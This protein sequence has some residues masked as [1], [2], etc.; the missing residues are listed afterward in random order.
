MKL[1]TCIALLLIFSATASFSQPRW[2]AKLRAKS[3]IDW[4][5][6][7]LHLSEDQLSKS[8]N[9][10]QVFQQQM[11]KAGETPETRDKAQQRLMRKKDM[12]MKAVLNKTQYQKYYDNQIQVRQRE[13]A[14]YKDG[15]RPL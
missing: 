3:E 5:K 10:V 4:M 14:T 15:H 7:N 13:R 12:D 9:I 11:D 8:V 2:N 6:E 1:T